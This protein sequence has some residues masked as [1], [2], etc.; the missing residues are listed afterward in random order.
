MRKTRLESGVAGLCADTARHSVLVRRGSTSG[1]S[2]KAAASPEGGQRRGRQ[3]GMAVAG[4]HQVED[5]LHA[6]DLEARRRA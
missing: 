4:A 6:G 1:R 3:H 2:V 5:G